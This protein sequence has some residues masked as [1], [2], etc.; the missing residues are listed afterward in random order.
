MILSYCL[1]SMRHTRTTEGQE[2][3]G[4]NQDERV[5]QDAG[6]VSWGHLVCSGD[7]V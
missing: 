1:E 4:E 3:A 7:T 6:I 2:E 5:H